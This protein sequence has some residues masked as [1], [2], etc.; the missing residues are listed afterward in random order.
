MADLD[1]QAYRHVLEHGST[2]PEALALALGVST[3]EAETAVANL[4][5]DRLLAPVPGS[6]GLLTA[7]SPRTAAAELVGEEEDALRRRLA[8]LDRTRARLTALNPLYEAAGQRR[9]EVG[10]ID[11]V[12]SRERVMTLISDAAGRCAHECLTVQPG[13]GRPA[14]HLERA[15]PRDLALISRG[16]RM[17]T[18][19]QHTARYS[20]PTQEYAAKVTAAGGEIRTLGELFGKMVI[21][22]RETAFLP[23]WDNPHAGVVLREPSAVAFLC[24]VFNTAWSLAEPFATSYSSLTANALRTTIAKMLADGSKD[25]VI[26]RKLGMSLRTCRRHISEMMEELGATSRFQAGYLLSACSPAA[27]PVEPP[28][29]RAATG[30]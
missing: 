3:G 16:V 20:P 1:I 8:E 25:E 17:R 21:F 28:P 23:V 30:P 27:A 22:D 13:G 6:D 26:A 29:A 5:R 9:G 11:V 12:D 18:L 19:Y 14:G 15:L 2:S 7:V 10:G 24:S 4:L